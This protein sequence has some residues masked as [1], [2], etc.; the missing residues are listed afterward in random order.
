MSRT[1]PLHLLHLSS[2]KK[3]SQHRDTAAVNA[4]FIIASGFVLYNDW[5]LI[6]FIIGAG[7]NVG[8]HTAAALKG[9]GYQVVLGSRAPVIDQV[10]M[11]ISP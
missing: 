8:E 1:S 3:F 7:K 2:E 10:K 9:K 11:D 6:A 4:E 5:T